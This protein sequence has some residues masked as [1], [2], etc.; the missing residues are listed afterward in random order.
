MYKLNLRNFCCLIVTAQIFSGCGLYSFTGASISPEVKTVSINYFS[1][2]SA[3]MVPSL[4]QSFTEALKDK[5]V[6]QTSLVLVESGGDLHFEGNIMDYKTTPINIQG[7]ETAAQSRLT[8]TVNLKFTNKNDDKKD[9]ESVFFR[10]ADYDSNLNLSD[11]E[12]DLIKDINNQLVEEIF[13]KAVV[14]W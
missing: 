11:I 14:N 4:S 3:I 5:F 12:E 9:F 13:N 2:N 7:N 8:I 10:F 6:S 1:N